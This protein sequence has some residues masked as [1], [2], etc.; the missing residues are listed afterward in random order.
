[1][2]FDNE[3][4]RENEL[5]AGS[6]EERLEE[7]NDNSDSSYETDPIKEQSDIEEKMEKED[8]IGSYSLLERESLLRGHDN[9]G[10]KPKDKHHNGPR[11]T[12]SILLIIVLS[13]ASGYVGGVLS[14]LGNSKMGSDGMQNS[15]KINI[16]VQDKGVN[17]A[18]AVA[19][20]VMPSVVGIKTEVLVQDI[21]GEKK[22]EGVGTGVIVDSKGYILTNSHVVND[23]ES[24]NIVVQLYDGRELKG[25][26]LWYDNVMDLS[27]VKINAEN[28]PA[29]ELGDSD[30]IVVGEYAVAIGNPLGLAFQ[31]TVTA[32]IISGLNRSIPVSDYQSIEGLIQTDASINPGNSGGPLLDAVG[33]V[34]GINTAKIQTAEGLG[35][36]IPI[37]VAKPIVDEFKAKGQFTRAYIGIKGVD[38]KQYIESYNEDL[39]TDTG[40]Y[41]YQIFANSPSSKAGL[42]E[43]DV[44]VKLGNTK[45][46]TMTELVA[47]LYKYRPDDQVTLEIVRNKQHQTINLT[48]VEMPK[49]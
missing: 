21:F 1:M 39:G 9:K 19:K 45:I 18:T 24:S 42:K 11:K 7:N 28:L 16:T 35:F 5:E 44:I 40:V 3:E 46:N 31:R 38:V 4:R 37:N 10:K 36:A 27:I 14:N 26:V 30:K 43:G 6:Q 33:K 15:Q 48:L 2:A 23:G 17:T 8:V 34:I 22:S 20:K 41:V 32:G 12:I 47:E 25:T 29:A 49:E 13:A